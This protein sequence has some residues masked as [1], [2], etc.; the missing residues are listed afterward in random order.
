MPLTSSA[1]RKD[2]PGAPK[3]PAINPSIRA[4]VGTVML[5][6]LGWSSPTAWP[7][8]WAATS[9]RTGA[10]QTSPSSKCTSPTSAPVQKKFEPV[11]VQECASVL[12]PEVGGPSMNSWPR[13]ISGNGW[14]P[15]GGAG[16]RGGGAGGSG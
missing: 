11:G 12:K 3:L 1:N 16:G 15:G 4:G 13:R 5:A 14:A 7:S 8:S 10:D 6:A 2:V 9:V